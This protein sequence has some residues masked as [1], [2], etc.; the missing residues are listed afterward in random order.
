MQGGNVNLLPQKL[1]IKAFKIQFSAG[2]WHR[3]YKVIYCS[4][5]PRARNVSAIVDDS[6]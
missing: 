3:M 1:K 2:L 6:T 5:S 4:G